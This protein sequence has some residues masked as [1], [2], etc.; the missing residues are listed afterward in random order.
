MHGSG[1]ED[2]KR[3]R[4]MWPVPDSTATTVA[5]TDSSDPNFFCKVHTFGLPVGLLLVLVLGLAFLRS[6]S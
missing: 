1:G 5:E 6:I 2:W 4:H 3:S